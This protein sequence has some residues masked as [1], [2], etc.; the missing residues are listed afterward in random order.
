MICVF[1]SRLNQ[2]KKKLIPNCF[3]LRTQSAPN[4]RNGEGAILLFVDTQYSNQPGSLPV[5]DQQFPYLIPKDYSLAMLIK[6]ELLMKFHVQ[7]AIV[8]ALTSIQLDL[9]V[10]DPQQPAAKPY[11]L[12]ATQGQLTVPHFKK[13]WKAD[14]IDRLVQSD[15]T[16]EQGKEEIPEPISIPYVDPTGGRRLNIFSGDP[17]STD[18]LGNHGIYF[19]WQRGA[20]DTTPNPR[21]DP[22]H[23]F[24]QIRGRSGEPNNP[25]HTTGT[26]KFALQGNF[27]TEVDNA[28][29]L[30]FRNR[31]FTWE[32][33]FLAMPKP[34]GFRDQEWKQKI[35]DGKDQH[36]TQKEEAMQQ[37]L[38][39][40]KKDQMQRAFKAIKIPDLRVFTVSHLLFPQQ[41]TAKWEQAGCPADLYVI[42]HI[43]PQGETYHITE[44]LVSLGPNYTKSFRLSTQKNTQWAIEPSSIGRIDANTG[45]YT[46]PPTIS[47][48]T[49]IKVTATNRADQNQKARATIMLY[50]SPIILKPSGFQFMYEDTKQTIHYQV[51]VLAGGPQEKNRAWSISPSDN[52]V[53]S[54][55][56]TGVFTPPSSFVDNVNLATITVT[57]TYQDNSKHYEY[58]QIGLIGKNTSLSQKIEPAYTEG[59]LGSGEELTLKTKKED[60]YTLNPSL[61][62]PSVGTLSTLTEDP[63]DRSKFIATYKAPNPPGQVPA[64]LVR[65]HSNT[66]KKTGFSFIQLKTVHSTQSSVGFFSPA[67]S[68]ESTMEI[69]TPT[70]SL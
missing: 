5:D 50:P 18:Q 3:E 39:K 49:Q 37:H 35:V 38:E 4:A 55:N 12:L 10:T 21:H 1:L 48:P 23:Y 47:Q 51:S 24:S 29:E 45:I 19:N 58:S 42:G 66:G 40:E 11:K 26:F 59:F 57:I 63:K 44:P 9:A 13:T 17:A 33:W 68:L 6:N 28:Y 2:L 65:V 20:K 15:K 27:S 41:H 67:P 53:G 69:P 54:I 25:Q 30:S 56:Q 16:H 64:V 14:N 46:A 52:S 34:Q 32:H 43:D 70:V 22:I 7:P 36:G 8:K 60:D 31:S 61:S 62:P